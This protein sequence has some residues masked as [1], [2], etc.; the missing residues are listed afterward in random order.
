[1][2]PGYVKP[3]LDQ[4]LCFSTEKETKVDGST[5][6][7]AKP[8]IVQDTHPIHTGVDGQKELIWGFWN[9]LFYLE[10]PLKDSLKIPLKFR[11]TRTFSSI[12]R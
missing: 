10:C 6:A 11:G 12:F 2:S 7:F 4:V 9:V 1:M 3:R 5:G 8:V